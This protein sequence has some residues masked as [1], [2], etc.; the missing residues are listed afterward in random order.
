[1]EH[2]CICNG[3]VIKTTTL[4]ECS[5][6]PMIPYGIDGP[7]VGKIPV[8]IAEPVVQIDVESIIELEEHALEIKRIKKNVFINQCK[9]IGIGHNTAKLFLS[10][11]VRK[12]IEFATAVCKNEKRDSISG[13][14]RH[15]TVNVPFNCV[16]KINFITPPKIVYQN[17]PK[18][19]SLLSEKT[20]MHHHDQCNHE[21]I[22]RNPCEQ[23]FEHFEEF[24]EPIF[25]ELVEARIF[26]SD[27][28][29]DIELL[30]HEFPTEHTF[31]KIEE[32]M[33]IL[34]KVKLL[35]KQQVHIPGSYKSGDLGTKK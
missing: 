15:T 1:M 6:E 31:K 32:K 10:G 4:P 9:V 23:S 13:N 14:I 27:L 22:G 21:V 3:G 24:N 29:K 19:L 16:T 17:N 8:V 20:C 7:V 34:V 30:H 33:V 5:N 2:E 11:F 18:E 28:H 35:Q 26:E 12:N 25:C